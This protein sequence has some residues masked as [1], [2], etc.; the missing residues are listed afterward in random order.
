[1]EA[2]GYALPARA[3]LGGLPPTLIHNDD[4]DAQRAS[5]EAFA[6]ALRA[7]GVDVELSC[8]PDVAHGHLNRPWMPQFSASIDEIVGFLRQPV[9]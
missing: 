6:E 7:A 9:R 3:D 1:M 4:Y 2:D 5:G 8:A